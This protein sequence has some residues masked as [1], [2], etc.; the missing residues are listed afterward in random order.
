MNVAAST[1][2]FPCSNSFTR[3]E[4]PKPSTLI[5]K[6]PKTE[7]YISE[8]DW[9]DN[10][11]HHSSLSNLNFRGALWQNQRNK[12]PRPPKSG[13]RSTPNWLPSAQKSWQLKR[14]HSY[15]RKSGWLRR[16]RLTKSFWLR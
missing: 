11:K 12:L 15:W 6:S 9:F 2:T 16:R 14:K 4:P 13:Q 5:A 1:P 8:T 10:E 3:T 7:Y